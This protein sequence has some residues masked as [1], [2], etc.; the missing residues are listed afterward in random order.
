MY[1]EIIY[2]FNIAQC[3]KINSYGIIDTFEESQCFYVY[4]INEATA[5][6]CW[7]YRGI[8]PTEWLHIHYH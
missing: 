1:T 3:T 4:S 2:F 8:E 5:I 7:Y 6:F